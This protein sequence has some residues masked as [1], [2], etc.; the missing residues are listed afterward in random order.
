MMQ[1][2][3]RSG[4]SMTTPLAHVF[5]SDDAELRLRRA[6]EACA[7]WLILVDRN[8]RVVFADRSCAARPQELCGLSV[9]ELLPEHDRERALSCMKGVLRIG[10]S[11]RF[12]FEMLGPRGT[13]RHIEMRVAP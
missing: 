11:D 2:S 6:A 13:P 3:E 12:E 4:D 10:A 5:E 1:G 9:L 7:D 8:L